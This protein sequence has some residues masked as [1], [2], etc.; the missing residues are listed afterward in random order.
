MYSSGIVA[1]LLFIGRGGLIDTEVYLLLAVTYILFHSDRL[2]LSDILPEYAKTYDKLVPP[3]VYSDP[4]NSSVHGM[5]YYE[6][7]KCFRDQ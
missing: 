7:T 4:N 5:S 2:E 6:H 3:V 1:L